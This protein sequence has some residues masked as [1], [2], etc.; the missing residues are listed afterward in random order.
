MASHGVDFLV[1]GDVNVDVI[2]GAMPSV[3]AIGVDTFAAAY[4]IALGGSGAITAHGLACMSNDVAFCTSV[5]DDLF[6]EFLVERLKR[7]AVSCLNH[8]SGDG[9]TGLSVA[10]SHGGDR[11][12]LSAPIPLAAWDAVP[13]VVR[14][15][16]PRHVH[17]ASHPHV[18]G[19]VE[20]FPA[21]VDAARAHGGTTSADP[22]GPADQQQDALTSFA[23]GATLDVLFVNESEA[24]AFARTPNADAAALALVAVSELVVL[25]RGAAGASLFQRGGK[26]L[27]E[28]GL[29]VRS[30]D[31][32]GAGDTF[33]SAFLHAWRGA[34]RHRLDICLAF[35]NAAA[36][37]SV[38]FLGGVRS[39]VNLPALFD[40][41]TRRDPTM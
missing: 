2:L 11:G 12:F 31:T 1:V 34:H 20:H 38:E 25:K 27:H 23:G 22:A 9:A 18:R 36:A 19:L 37:A 33:A 39:H 32:T 29:D 24:R 4:E 17:V 28:K 40:A 10:F 5:G 13:G 15:L 35:A 6:G 8:R 14:S 21:I 41:S 16:A 30:V 26:A 3:P 7:V